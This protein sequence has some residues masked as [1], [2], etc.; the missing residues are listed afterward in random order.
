MALKCCLT[1]LLKTLP[2]FITAAIIY[3]LRGLQINRGIPFWVPG[4]KGGSGQETLLF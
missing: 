4:L 2:S 1:K 3:S